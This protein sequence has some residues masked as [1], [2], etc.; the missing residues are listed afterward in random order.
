MSLI[1]EME[2]ERLQPTCSCCGEY[3]TLD[4]WE[5]NDDICDRCYEDY[6]EAAEYEAMMFELEE[7][8]DNN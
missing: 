1:D 7:S 3:L 2:F 5:S 6:C 8:F 4:E